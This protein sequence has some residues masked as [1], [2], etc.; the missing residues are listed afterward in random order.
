MDPKLLSQLCEV[1]E[2]GSLSRAALSL[3]VTQPTLTRNMKAI[4]MSIGAPVLRRGRYGVTPTDIGERLAEQG[5]LISAAMNSANETI[6]TWRTGL[7]GEVRLGIGAMQ[8][9]SLLPA[10][11]AANPMKESSFTM[12]MVAGDYSG[13]MQKLRQHEIDLAILP[14]YSNANMETVMQ[15]V[16]FTDQVCVLAGANSPLNKLPGEV[17]SRLLSAQTWISINNFARTRHI[18]DEVAQLLGIVGKVPKF[19]FEGDV[20]ASMS[21]LR[22]S[23][24]LALAPRRFAERYSTM[25]GFKILEI[26]VE[27]PRRNIA[28]WV[29]KDNKHDTCIIEVSKIIKNHFR[30]S[31]VQDHSDAK[32]QDVTNSD[33][34]NPSVLH[35]LELP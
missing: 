27:L 31:E 14:S 22:N 17:S 18:R 7:V 25:G 10:F 21:L 12:C 4:E 28:L 24:M 3:D 26:D 34:T 23:D 35:E 13:L 11:F 19:R 1:I 6:E 9:A 15:D 32:N 16:L 30:D 33:V 8:S 2:Q 29:N 5:R 20:T